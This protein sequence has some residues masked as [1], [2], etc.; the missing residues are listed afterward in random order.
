MVRIPSDR[1][2]THLGEMLLKEFLEPMKI[3]EN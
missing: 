1:I 2:P 3:T